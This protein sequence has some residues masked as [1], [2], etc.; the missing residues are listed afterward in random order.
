[1]SSSEEKIVEYQC[2]AYKILNQ[3]KLQKKNNCYTDYVVFKFGINDL[4]TFST[5]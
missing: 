2:Q 3:Q 5:K 4:K 1:M